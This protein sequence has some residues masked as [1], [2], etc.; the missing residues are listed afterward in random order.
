M[1]WS[2]MFQ[3]IEETCE[4]HPPQGLPEARRGR[5]VHEI[6]YFFVTDPPGRRSSLIEITEV[7]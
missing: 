5:K 2:G 1:S 6:V 4:G 3:N 7:Y